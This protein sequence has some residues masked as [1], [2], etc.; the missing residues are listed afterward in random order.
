MAG[1]KAFTLL[2][3]CCLLTMGFRC[4]KDNLI[5]PWEHTFEVPVDIAPLKKTYLLTDTIWLET[6]ITGKMLYDTLSAQLITIDTGSL[7][8]RINFSPFG[9]NLTNPANGFCDVI[10]NGGVNTNRVLAHRSTAASIDNVGCRQ[11]TFKTRIGFKP[12]YKGVYYLALQ[13][14]LMIQN[15]PNKVKPDY[16]SFFFRYKPV[17][18]NPDVFNSLSKNDQG[19]KAGQKYY[20]EKI[21]R[22]E[23][24]VFRVN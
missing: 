19:R 15:C 10:T 2:S 16:S 22:R 3:A 21:N 13:S 23:I 7:S 17:D 5:K 14:D 24:F 6:A 8:F 12:N 18:L 20:T 9:T 11:S 4:E 1:K